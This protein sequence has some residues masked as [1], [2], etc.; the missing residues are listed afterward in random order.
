M[1]TSTPREDVAQR[2][3][4]IEKGAQAAHE[5]WLADAAQALAAVARVKVT[6]HSGDVWAELERRGKAEG[7]HDGRAMATVMQR[8]KRDGICKPTDRSVQAKVRARNLTSV[9]V[10]ESLTWGD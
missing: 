6:F 7:S 5:Q 1:T 10:W 2:D 8:G 3:A 4:A 9:R